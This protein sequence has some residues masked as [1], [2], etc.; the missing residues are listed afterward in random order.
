MYETIKLKFCIGFLS[1]FRIF[2]S[3]R[4]HDAH[5]YSKYIPVNTLKFFLKLISSPSLQNNR[6]Q[7][8]L[9]RPGRYE[10]LKTDVITRQ[11]VI[12]QVHT[13]SL[14]VIITIVAVEKTF[15]DNLSQRDTK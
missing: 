2:R 12:Q 4:T 13:Q 1:F 14:I 15:T 7:L 8:M 11:L 6:L 3:Q 9:T 5:V 10:T